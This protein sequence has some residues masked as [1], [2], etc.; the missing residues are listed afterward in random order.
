MYR[1]VVEAFE[2]VVSG[3]E[4]GNIGSICGFIKISKDNVLL[5]NG[6]EYCSVEITCSN[7]I[8]YG[9]EAF[10]EEAGELR[11]RAS[12]LSAFSSPAHATPVIRG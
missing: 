2:D 10:G 8:Q 4:E 9:I 3:K 11:R 5:G 6:M 1:G 12:E 7:G